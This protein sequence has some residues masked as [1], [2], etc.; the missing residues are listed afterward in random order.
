MA[1]AVQ[2]RPAV[3]GTLCY[4]PVALFGSVMGLTGL[5]VGWR[6]AHT[7]FGTPAWI[8][9]AVGDVAL[10]TFAALAI[11]YQVKAATSFSSVRAE[12]THPI[13]GNLFGTLLISLLLVPLLLADRYLV[14]ARVVWV[15]GAVSM[16]LFAWLIVMRWISVRQKP[17]HATPAWIVPVVG[18]IDV[19]LAVPALG[20]THELHG[21]MVFATAIGLFFAVPLFTMILSRLMF[22]EPMPDALQPALLI[23]VA[24]FAVGFSAYTATTGAVDGFATSLYMLMPFILAVLIARMRHLARCCPFRV[25]WWSV[26]FP[27]A[28]CADA[29]LSYASFAQNL[30]SD[31]VAALLLALA[32]LVIAML[33]VRTVWGIVRVNYAH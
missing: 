19:P 21:L 24:P 7:H 2:T 28:A 25:S 6:L 13:S 18:M 9:D 30:V 4:L 5:A 11:A 15:V 26:S 17:A 3:A 27:L 32:S 12:F 14:F 1:P 10:A 8:A 20:W 22:E 33:F 16:T 23:L 31:I 29:A